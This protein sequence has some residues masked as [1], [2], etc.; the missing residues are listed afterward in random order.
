MS[1]A[2]PSSYMAELFPE[3]IETDRLELDALTPDAVPVFEFYEHVREG[4]PD[5]DE[6]TEHLTWSPHRTPKETREFYDHVASQ[7]EADEAQTYA[8]RPKAGEDGA[9]E[10][11]GVT[12]IDVDWDA[13]T[14]EFGVWFRK[15]F[16]GRGYSGER[17]GALMEMAF[18][19]LD[20]DAVVVTVQRGNEESR[21]AV[22]RY[23][24]VH[25]GRHEGLLR[26]FVTN[27][28]GTAVDAHR[29]TVTAAEYR[30]ATE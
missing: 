14:A 17:A 23:V 15:P 9:G 19:R 28:D 16:W 7:R 11:A 24:E 30:D 26:N 8:I 4:A 20:L 6:V 12:G 21:T 13:R 29:Y 2:A 27:Q 1:A 25:G 10:F 22:S 3:R 18:E 5:I